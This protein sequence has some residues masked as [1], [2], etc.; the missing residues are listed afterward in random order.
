MKYYVSRSKDGSLTKRVPIEGPFISA[1]AAAT[2]AKANAKGFRTVTVLEDR[3]GTDR[4]NNA[5]K[6][7]LHRIIK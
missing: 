3:C 4:Q 2:W 5:G 6:A 7:F 1:E